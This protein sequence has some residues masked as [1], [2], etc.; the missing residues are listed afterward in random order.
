MRARNHSGR[1]TPEEY[2]RPGKNSLCYPEGA[3][4]DTWESHPWRTLAPEGV[5]L[6]V[7]RPAWFRA[8]IA[9]W[10]IWFT[11]A[12]SEAPGAHACAVHGKHSAHAAPA[13][14]HADHHG[15]REAPAACT[16]LGLCC[17][18]SPVGAPAVSL[19]LADDILV[20][21]ADAQFPQVASAAIRRAHS[22]P[23]A[24]GPPRI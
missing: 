5:L 3:Q 7:R 16:C 20:V 17:C 23:F 1:L 10:G 15:D 8:L 9:V 12:L 13:H 2:M 11:A 21:A 22:L 6:G 24:N 18:A 4:D 19:G 14:D